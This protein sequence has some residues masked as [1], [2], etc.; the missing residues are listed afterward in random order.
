RI[1]RHYISP[2]APRRLPLPPRDR[3]ACLRAA[4]HT[5][6]PSALLPAFLLA[7]TTLRRARSHPQFVRWARANANASRV[8]FLRVLGA[9]LVLLGVGVDVVLVL[10]R[11]GPYWRVGCWLLWWL[12]FAVLVAAG[13]GVC[14]VLHWAGGRQVRPWEG[15]AEEEKK[16]GDDDEG[17]W[18]GHKRGDTSSTTVSSA[19]SSSSS[20]STASGV[21]PLRK[22]SLQVFGPANDYSRELW[23]KSYREKGVMRRVFDETVVVQNKGLASWQDRTVLFSL[24][25]GGAGATALTVVSLFV[26]SGRLF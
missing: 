1:T 6:H 9:V 16:G 2:S 24:L 21:D 22:P 18:T 17:W 5:T 11:L 20:S 13:R 4:Q 8:L 25:W 10:S 14:L 26:P 7:E 19:S 12:G 23:M 3:D 15:V